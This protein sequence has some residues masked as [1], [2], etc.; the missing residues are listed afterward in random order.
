MAFGMEIL[1]SQYK[2]FRFSSQN[3]THNFAFWRPPRGCKTF[4]SFFYVCRSAHENL[5]N[6]FTSRLLYLPLD[7]TLSPHVQGGFLA[8]LHRHTHTRIKLSENYFSLSSV[9]SNPQIYISL[10]HALILSLHTRFV[11][12]EGCFLDR[13][14]YFIAPKN[15]TK[16][17]A[18]REF[19]VI[20]V[21]TAPINVTFHSPLMWFNYKKFLSL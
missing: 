2:F 20:K 11:V 6:W 7:Q 3:P 19:I 5:L 1:F 17:I 15:V 4:D 13:W 14:K 16:I 8:I 9:V 10:D 21:S 18:E 12:Q